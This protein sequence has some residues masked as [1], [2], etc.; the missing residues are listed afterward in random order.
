MKICCR[1]SRRRSRSRE[2]GQT[3]PLTILRVAIAE[4]W[5]LYLFPS[6]RGRRCDGLQPRAPSPAAQQQAFY[7]SP[8]LT[9]SRSA[10]SP[11]ILSPTPSH[12]RRTM[13]FHSWPPRVLLRN[14]TDR[15]LI[16]G[17]FC[18]SPCDRNRRENMIHLLL[19]S[20]LRVRV[21]ECQ[22]PRQEP[23]GISYTSDRSS[24]ACRGGS[25]LLVDCPTLMKLCCF[26]AWSPNT[27]KPLPPSRCP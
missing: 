4:C 27:M 16:A 11:P 2:G 3:P 7:Q 1:P 21:L 25:H 14:L 12:R 23:A 9:T 26:G 6:I 5:T 18:L 22:S 10:H 17:P 24:Q 15:P 20:S 8:D 19:S 13:P